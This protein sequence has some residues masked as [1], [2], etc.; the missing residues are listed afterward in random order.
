MKK[1]NV[2]PYQ[3]LPFGAPLIEYDY[4]FVCVV[5]SIH[6]ILGNVRMRMACGVVSSCV[7]AHSLIATQNVTVPRYYINS[8]RIMIPCSTKVSEIKKAH[9]KV[10]NEIY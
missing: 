3:L 5:A 7:L 6:P 2:R 4:Y 10:R 8:H 1:K 9:S